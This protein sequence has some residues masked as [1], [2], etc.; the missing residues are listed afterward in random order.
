MS[1]QA[2]ARREM[3]RLAALARIERSVMGAHE[4]VEDRTGARAMWSL[5]D[6]DR[7]AR[8]MVWEFGP[9]LVSACAVAPGERLLD[10]ACGTGNVALRAA[11]AGAVVVG[12]DITPEHF[13]HGRR[14]ARE[15]GVEI[16][17]VHA[18]AGA[19]P[20]ADASFDVV[21]SS[22]GAIFAPDHRA[23]AGELARVCRPGGTIGMINFTPG[24]TAGGFFELFAR[25]APAPPEGAEAPILW[26]DERHLRELFGDRIAELRLERRELVERHPGAPAD[27]WAYY[28]ETFGPVVALRGL[29]ASEPARLA[30]FDR[31]CLTF[32]ERA[33]VGAPEG[34]TELRYGYV[35]AVA[36]RAPG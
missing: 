34:P 19:L 18:D 9:V 6:Y 30:A 11:R 20:F 17:W 1:S 7:F 26:G 22:A 33:N 10:V 8:E 36:R 12:A 24:G 29:L 32:V 2:T 27:Y 13:E 15:L 5:G 25:H 16:E 4:V 21:T 14:A 31:D 35:V 23:V 28:R 3:A